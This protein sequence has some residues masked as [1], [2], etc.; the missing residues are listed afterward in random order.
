M[1]SNPFPC[2]TASSTC[3]DAP[4]ITFFS[5]PKPFRDHIEII[6]RNAIR[7]WTMLRPRPQIILFGDEP[8][9]ANLANEFGLE[10]I[11]DVRRNQWGT[12]L[13]D[14]MF[15]LAHKLARHE[16]MTYINADII[17]LSDFID[18]VRQLEC[19][20]F[21]NYLMIGR[22]IDTDIREPI[23]FNRDD[24]E[25][26]LR[27]TVTQHGSLAPRVCKDYFVYRKPLFAEI[28][29][30][31]IGRAVYDNW[32]VF[33]ARTQGIPVV[34]A[35]AVVTAIHQNHSHA[36]VPGGRGSAY[37]KGEEAKQNRLLAGGMH[38]VKG[39]TATWKLTFRGVR[40]RKVPSDL[41]Q[42]L[43]DL[44]RFSLLVLELF[45]MK[46]GCKNAE[47]ANRKSG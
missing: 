40:R 38:L 26:A 17:L 25:F 5:M 10:H 31:A 6:Q 1:T 37:L 24:W 34:D 41:V 30:F 22:R 23:D 45:G 19:A 20:N 39:S 18:A 13:M 12:L 43:L 28:P 16:T 2:D 47:K 29:A 44:P 15:R 4:A 3:R 7:S 21:A 8:G 46:S 9:T 33:Q 35:T 36:H 32:F 14:D 11:P 27:Q 42:F